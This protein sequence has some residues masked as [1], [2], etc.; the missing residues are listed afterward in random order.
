MEINKLLQ[1]IDLTANEANIYLIALKYG[2]QPAS[3]LAKRAKI[4]R[5]TTYSSIKT[6]LEKGLLKQNKKMQATYFSAISPEA[7]INFV[8]EKKENL[9]K[10]INL[11]K[12]NI[13]EF[14]SLQG[15]AVSKPEVTFYENISGLKQI[16]QDIL[17]T[18]ENDAIYSFIPD[19]LTF[20]EITIDFVKNRLKNNIE[21]KVIIPESETGRLLQANDIES[22]RETKIVPKDKYNFQSEITV[23]KEK[24]ALISYKP[25]EMIGLIV[26]SPAISQTMK[27]IFELC[28]LENEIFLPTQ[29]NL[30]S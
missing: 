23:Y 5:A 14:K 22:R 17:K 1:E 2:T 30:F 8:E 10:K 16:H 21:S 4:N 13:A 28:F 6:L 29:K 3:I 20:D 18:A 15:T 7:L 11:L 25:E 12:E 26:E 27:Q 19:N 24:I 9:D